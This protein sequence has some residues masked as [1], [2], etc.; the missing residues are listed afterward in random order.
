MGRIREYPRDAVAGFLERWHYMT[1]VPTKTS[2][3]FYGYEDEAGLACVIALNHRPVNQKLVR[4]LFM[5]TDKLPWPQREEDEQWHRLNVGELS[6]MACRD[7]CPRRT[8]S[9]FLGRC[10]EMVRKLGYDAVTS[11]SDMAV[12]H[13]GTIYRATNWIYTG[14]AAGNPTFLVDTSVTDWWLKDFAC[15]TCGVCRPMHLATHE[16]VGIEL[17]PPTGEWQEVNWRQCRHRWN[18][19]HEAG[20]RRVLGDRLRVEQGFIKHRFVYLLSR[21]A[22]RMFERETAR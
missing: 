11:Y 18:A 2:L 1:Y 14:E 22:K 5:P 20:L 9:M 12:G 16:F 7:E 6:R 10:L 17:P 3:K 15:Q 19:S 8:E 4:R 13:E 21:E